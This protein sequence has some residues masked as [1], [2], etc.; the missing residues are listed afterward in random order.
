MA[1]L[2]LVVADEKGQRAIRPRTSALGQCRVDLCLAR[3]P[4]LRKEFAAAAGNSLS[5]SHLMSP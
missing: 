5:E 4:P 1:T 2:R 3:E